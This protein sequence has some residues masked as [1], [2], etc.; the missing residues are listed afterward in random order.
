MT[1]CGIDQ[2]IG[3]ASVGAHVF[4][5]VPDAEIRDAKFEGNLEFRI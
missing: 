5:R 1:N 2:K 4:L 3:E